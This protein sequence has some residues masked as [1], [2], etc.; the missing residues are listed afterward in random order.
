MGTSRSSSGPKPDC[1]LIPPWLDVPAQPPAQPPAAPPI[2]APG[3]GGPSNPPAPQPQPPPAP[4]QPPLQPNVAPPKRFSEARRSL[5]DFVR[6]GDERSMRRGIGS[7]VSKGYGGSRG[8]AAR[9]GQAATTASRAFNILSSLAEG[10]ASTEQLGFDPTTLAG[11]P[12]DDVVNALVD[13]ICR[14]D[15]TLDDAAGRQAVNDALAEVLEANPGLDPLAMTPLA[16]NEVYLRT[17]S[18]HVFSDL[19]LDIGTTMQKAADGNY[20]LYNDRCITIRDTIREM[21]RE[22]FQGVRD[23]GHRVTSATSDAIARDVIRDVMD[24]FEGWMQ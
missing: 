10:T 23:A 20:V 16:I 13:G 1:G 8:A 4:P 17:V 9:M 6:D 19:L 2:L 7:Y 14:N 3:D 5:G 12:V 24:V 18:Y 11:R 22:K 15:T 21:F